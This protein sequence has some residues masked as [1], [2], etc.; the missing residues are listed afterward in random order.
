MRLTLTLTLNYFLARSVFLRDYSED[1]LQAAVQ[2]IG[3]KFGL[4][5]GFVFQHDTGIS[6]AGG[7]PMA[8]AGVRNS[9]ALLAAKHLK[10]AL[11]A[12]TEGGRNFF[13][14]LAR[15]DGQLGPLPTPHRKRRTARVHQLDYSELSGTRENKHA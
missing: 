7:A 15:L 4:P 5:S 10:R 8:A 11:E 1:T 2:L 13:V 12:P 3:D 14:C 6:A 9:W